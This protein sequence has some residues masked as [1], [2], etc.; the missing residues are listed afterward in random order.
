MP[1]LIVDSC[2][3]GSRLFTRALEVSTPNQC[4]V[5]NHVTRVLILFW[6]K[7]LD[8]DY[9]KVMAVFYISCCVWQT[10]QQEDWIE[11]SCRSEILTRDNAHVVRVPKLVCRNQG[12]EV[13]TKLESVLCFPL[14]T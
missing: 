11:N 9:I 2:E 1:F 3:S 6:S 14:I 4:R 12:Y 5:N 8:S 13:L 7:I 10:K